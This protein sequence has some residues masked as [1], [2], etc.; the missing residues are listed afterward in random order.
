[1]DT[2][3]LSTV[4]EDFANYSGVEGDQDVHLLN[5]NLSFLL[6]HLESLSL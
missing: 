3:T 1:M 6:V 2:D 4:L 5:V